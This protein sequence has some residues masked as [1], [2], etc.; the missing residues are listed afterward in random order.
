[1]VEY[2]AGGT[3]TTA[4][5]PGT[6]TAEETAGGTPGAEA[7]AGASTGTEENISMTPVTGLTTLS[8]RRKRKAKGWFCPVCRRP[9]TSML[10][11]TTTAPPVPIANEKG[12][13]SGSEDEG[14]TLEATN[15]SPPSNG[16]FLNGDA[17]AGNSGF[18]R[19][20]SGFLRT[21]S[22]LGRERPADIENQNQNTNA[23]QNRNQ[24][25]STP[26]N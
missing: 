3:I 7:V 23:N 2:G 4:T 16:N 20:R 26:G 1:M 15:S 13:G 14:D 19:P 12:D 9:Y 18:F 22:G 21:L 11:L 25:E 5:E 8:P 17:P 10:R 24:S 6:G